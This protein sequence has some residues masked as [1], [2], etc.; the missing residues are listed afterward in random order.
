VCFGREAGNGVGSELG[1]QRHD[2]V[3]V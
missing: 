1:A 2:Q 3:V